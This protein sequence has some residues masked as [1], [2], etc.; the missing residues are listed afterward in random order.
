[1][2]SVIALVAAVVVV[3]VVIVIVAS[4]STGGERARDG[5][6]PITLNAQE[7]HGRQLFS[8]RCAGCHVLTATGA[9]G[10]TG[11]SLDMLRPPALAT[12]SAIRRGPGAMPANLVA[13][14]DA[15]AVADFVAA[16][17]AH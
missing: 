14:R 5:L 10:R 4:H 13:G 3:T 6:G 8:Q 2:T 16:V 15:Q 12:L 9:V 11:P 7:R 1:M 17:T